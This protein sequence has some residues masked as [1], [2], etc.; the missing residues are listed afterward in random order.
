M[1]PEY[2]KN[3]ELLPNSIPSVT[4]WSVNVRWCVKRTGKKYFSYSLLHGMDR[5]STTKCGPPKDVMI[6]MVK[7]KCGPPNDRGPPNECGHNLSGKIQMWS[8]EWRH[9]LSGNQVTSEK[10]SKYVKP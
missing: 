5:M 2:D 1:Q 3:D 8:T 9:N 10:L 4:P 7:Y 6:S